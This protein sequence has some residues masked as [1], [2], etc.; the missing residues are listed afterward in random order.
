M[1]IYSYFC[2]ECSEDYECLV[3]IE[4]R[5]SV[6]CKCGAKLVRRIDAARSVYSPT[7]TGGQKVR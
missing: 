7:A 3:N 5:D 4:D 2:E 6:Q 1:P